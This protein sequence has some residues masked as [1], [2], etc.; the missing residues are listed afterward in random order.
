M[1]L[2]TIARRIKSDHGNLE[3]SYSKVSYKVS[4]KDLSC[5]AILYRHFIEFCW[6]IFFVS[7]SDIRN[8]K[9]LWAI[10]IHWFIEVL[11]HI[12]AVPLSFLDLLFVLARKYN[13]TLFD[14]LQRIYIYKRL[15]PRKK[16][17]QQKKERAE[18]IILMKLNTKTL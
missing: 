18:E 8:N 12:R 15:R 13:N 6:F 9:V 11:G 10:Y 3:E 1:V 14:G 4:L 5:K 7:S 17:P 16:N 2:I